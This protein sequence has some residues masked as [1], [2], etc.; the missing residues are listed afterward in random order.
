[1]LSRMAQYSMDRT[2]HLRDDESNERKVVDTPLDLVE[3]MRNLKVGLQI[4]EYENESIMRA[5]EK[6]VQINVILL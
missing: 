5:Q 4:C 1:M 6:H 2:S 3:T